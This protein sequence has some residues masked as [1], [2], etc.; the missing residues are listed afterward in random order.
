MFW[1]PR[2]AA[3]IL[4]NLFQRIHTY[5]VAQ[6]KSSFYEL[7]KT[8]GAISIHKRSDYAYLL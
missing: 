1:L 4:F 7:D 6:F 5:I 3:Y 8:K 2:Y